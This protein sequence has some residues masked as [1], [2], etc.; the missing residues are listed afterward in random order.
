MKPTKAGLGTIGDKRNVKGKKRSALVIYGGGHSPYGTEFMWSFAEAIQGEKIF[1]EVYIGY[2]SF[3]CF[4]MPEKCIKNFCDVC[5]KYEFKRLSPSFFGTS[6]DIDFEASESDRNAAIAVCK[7]LRITDIYLSGGDGSARH[8]KAIAEYFESEGIAWHFTMPCTIDGI[9]KG[10]GLGLDAAVNETVEYVIETAEPNLRTL[11]RCWFSVAEVK[12]MG[13]NRDNI[14][15]GAI[16]KIVEMKTIADY[17]INEVQIIALPANYDVDIANLKDKLDFRKMPNNGGP[18]GKPTLILRSEGSK[19][20]KSTLKEICS[21]TGVKI[22]CSEVGYPAQGGKCQKKSTIRGIKFMILS[23][24]PIIR[25]NVGHSDTIVFDKF[26]GEPHREHYSYFAEANPQ[27]VKATL[28]K[29]LEEL[30]LK[31]VP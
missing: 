6:R 29:D 9:E 28:P 24:L 15:A 20:T 30:L 14:L 18:V 11:E 3:A 13:R 10:Y 4:L 16:K 22:R 19:I 25:K 27:K 23:M 1:E 31:Y 21:E 26:C 8:A 7:K 2:Y 5:G 17:P 12:V